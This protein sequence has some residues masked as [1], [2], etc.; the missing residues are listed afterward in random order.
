MA[1]KIVLTD[2]LEGPEVVADAGTI[3]FVFDGVEYSVDLSTENATRLR[4]LLTPYMQAARSRPLNKK[5]KPSRRKASTPVAAHLSA[6]RQWARENGYEVNEKGRVS[7][8][9]IL[10]Y[11]EAHTPKGAAPKATPTPVFSG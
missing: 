3:T 7:R 5:P 9:I 11:D 4:A 6:V 8:E 2:D 10:A 1:E